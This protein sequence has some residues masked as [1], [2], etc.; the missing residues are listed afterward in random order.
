MAQAMAKASSVVQKQ[1][2]VNEEMDVEEYRLKHPFSGAHATAKSIA[3]TI[4]NW[5]TGNEIV[6]KLEQN[7]LNEISMK[8]AEQLRDALKQKGTNVNHTIV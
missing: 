2:E 6:Y 3:E 5:E 7:R 4:N 8:A 1:L